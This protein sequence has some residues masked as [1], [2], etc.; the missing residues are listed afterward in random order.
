M[1]IDPGLDGAIA[2]I[3][4][5]GA[6]VD[7]MPVTP[8]R[9]VAVVSLAKILDAHDPGMVILEGQ[10]I[11]PGKQSLSTVSRA[12]QNWGMVYGALLA[13]GFPVYVVKP[14]AWKAVV[15]KGTQKDKAA[16]ITYAIRRFGEDKLIP[17]GRKVFHDGVA[18]ALC[19][20]AYG[21]TLR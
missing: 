10:L 18:D 9:E 12:A 2:T 13:K 7:L 6:I 17:P 5:G 15:L 8:G 3:A 11:I 20:A 16:A 14:Q 19:M 4:E 21:E 1:G